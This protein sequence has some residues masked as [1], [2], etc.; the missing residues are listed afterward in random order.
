MQDQNT[1]LDRAIRVI[2]AISKAPDGLRFSDVALTLDNPSPSTVSKILKVLTRDGVLRKTPDGRY[3]LGRKIYFWGRV[4]ASLNPPIQIIREQMRYLHEKHHVSVNLF[5]CS[6]QTMFCLECFMDSKSPFLY[7]AGKSLPMHLSVQGAVFF[8]SPDKLR[9]RAFLEKE[10]ASHEDSLR[11]EDLQKMVDYAQSN[12]LQDDF[13]LFYPGIHR[14]S[15]PIRENG[16]TIMTLGVGVSL[17]RTGDGDL[18]Q[19]IVADL[20]RIRTV[21]EASF[22]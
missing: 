9:D 3:T 1:I 20:R 2:D 12:D 22:D 13:A 4:M 17:K 19:R 5:T 15:A 18:A 14:F 7:P 10:A 21:I 16:R 8:I 11:V 6:G